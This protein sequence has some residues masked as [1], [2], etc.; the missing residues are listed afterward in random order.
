[1]EIDEARVDDAVLALLLLGADDDRRASRRFDADS[2]DRLFR[3]GLIADPGGR[4][5]SVVLTDAGL[6][7]ARMLFSRMFARARP[8]AG[9]PE[10]EG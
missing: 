2:L 3:R 1:M 10:A 6:D 4:S 8:G 7:R 5:A 9:A